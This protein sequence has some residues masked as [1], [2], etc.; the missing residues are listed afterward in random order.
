ME[1]TTE[2]RFNMLASSELAKLQGFTGE[3][4]LPGHVPDYIRKHEQIVAREEYR[5]MEGA[6][7]RA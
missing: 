3:V 5:R 4:V 6:L 2:S 1:Q 7:R